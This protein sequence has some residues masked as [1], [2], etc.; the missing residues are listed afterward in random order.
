MNL[1]S[2]AGIAPTELGIHSSFLDPQMDHGKPFRTSHATKKT[3]EFHPHGRVDIMDKF[4]SVVLFLSSFEQ[5]TTARQSHPDRTSSRYSRSFFLFSPPPS[6]ATFCY[7][8]ES[9][10][11]GG[12]RREQASNE[13]GAMYPRQ[14]RKEKKG[15]KR[16][17]YTHA[18]P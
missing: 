6:R 7:Q 4:V 5:K 12:E 1:C 2:P 10:W 11:R 18:V 3:C 17:T 15:E 14:T 13:A 16:T 8:P 9:L